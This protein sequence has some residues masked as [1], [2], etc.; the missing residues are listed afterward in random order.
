MEKHLEFLQGVINRH[1]SNSFMLKGWTIT[2]TAALFAL[3]GTVKEPN[4][5][6]IALSPILMFWGLD[7]F[8]LSNERCFVDLF[9]AVAKG[10]YKLPKKKLFKSRQNDDS[11]E[12]E[13]G[14]ISNFDMNF[15]KFKVWKNNRWFQVLWSK[16]ILWFYFSMLLITIII[17]AL[18]IKLKIQDSK[19]IDINA[20]LKSNE[21]EMNVNAE[22][23]TIINNVYP[24][25]NS[26]DSTKEPK[27][28]TKAKN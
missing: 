22:P 5:V 28:E 10:S 27:K 13:T 6:F 23:P 21:L 16:T 25:V 17:M 26:I 24:L 3:A 2:I 1:N 12:F 20:T 8:Y 4:I 7:A 11:I 9:N 15:K 18:F 19:T 14:L